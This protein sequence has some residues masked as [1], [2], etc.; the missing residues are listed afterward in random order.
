MGVRLFTPRA[1]A[2]EGPTVRIRRD[3]S[4]LLLLMLAAYVSLALAS[5]DLERPPET[6]WMGPVGA[7]LAQV[8]ATAFG[9]VAWLVPLELALTAVPLLRRRT[10]GPLGMRLSGNLM[11]AI[12][13]A[14]L[15]QVAFPDSR[16]QRFLPAGGNVG[17]FFGEIMRGLFSA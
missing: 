15:T 3:A 10:I 6:N 12:I 14:S 17:L 1:A 7:G 9:V 16:Y 11:L 5:L 2:A 8:L 4:A 13:T